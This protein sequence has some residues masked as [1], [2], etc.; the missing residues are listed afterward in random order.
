THSELYFARYDARNRLVTGG[1][2]I[3][4]YKGRERLQR[5]IGQRLQHLWPAMG[6]VTFDYVWNGFVG[7]TRDFYPRFHQLGPQ[8][9]AWTGCNGRGVGLSVAIGREFARALTGTA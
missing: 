2:L 5:M 9:L 4:S 1:N 6:E 3:F 7:M 8:A